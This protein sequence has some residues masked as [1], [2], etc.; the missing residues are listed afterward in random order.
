MLNEFD[1]DIDKK[2]IAQTP[3]E[4]RDKSRL[5]VV[6]GNKI[7]HRFFYQIV[8]ELKENSLI[9]LN[10]SKVIPAKFEGIKVSQGGGKVKVTLTREIMQNRWECI[11]EG[12]H[13]KEGIIIKFEPGNFEGRLV[14]WIKEGIYIIEISGNVKKLMKQFGFI[15]LPHYIRKRPPD[16]SRYQTV[17]ASEEGS[18]AAPTAGLHFTT[19]LIDEL[20]EK[21]GI[22]FEFITLHVGLGSILPLRNV[23]LTKQ[24]GYPEFYTISEKTAAKINEWKRNNDEI[25]VVG[26][27]CLKALESAADKSGKIH[28]KSEI[29]DLFIHPK[30]QF[31]FKFNKFITNFHLPKAPPFI[32]TGSLVGMEKLKRVYEIAKKKEYRFYSFGDSMLV[33]L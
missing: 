20:R 13:L 24:H 16:I 22:I 31:K 14:E 6:D 15:P 23:D 18:I 32:L 5:L 9:I 1:Y 19:E 2:F 10:N 3:L 11:V 8:D 27:T 26:T 30:Y 17:Y 12:R 25:V 7:R 21:K 33:F 4:K 28:S 29:S